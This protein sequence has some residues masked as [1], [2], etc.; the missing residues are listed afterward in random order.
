MCFRSLSR[1]E[2]KT[3]F[4]GVISPFLY[5]GHE[6]QSCF[7]EKMSNVKVQDP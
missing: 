4:R 5:V 2:N 7:G 3:Y 6:R 1:T